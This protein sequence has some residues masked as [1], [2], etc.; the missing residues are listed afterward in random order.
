MT[1]LDMLDRRLDNGRTLL[2]AVE[3]FWDEM[4]GFHQAISKTPS[5]GS[6]MLILPPFGKYNA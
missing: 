5:T 1:R 3:K 4:A 6:I 2:S